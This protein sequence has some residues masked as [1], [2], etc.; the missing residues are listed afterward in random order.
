MKEIEYKRKMEM[1]ELKLY[2][3]FMLIISH[4]SDP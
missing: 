4:A 2:E 1:H 3:Y